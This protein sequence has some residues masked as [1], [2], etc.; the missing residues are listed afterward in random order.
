MLNLTKAIYAKATGTNFKAALTGLYKGRAPENVD[1]PYAVYKVVTD[2]PDKTF[3]EDY[4]DVT[5]QFS[6]FSSSNGTTE[7]ENIYTQLKAVYDECELSI[8][9]ATLVWMKRN[10]AAFQA[11]EHTTQSGMSRIWAYHV[12]YSILESLT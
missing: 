6:L 1:Y 5:L 3:S 2:V 10:Y 4:E 9:G 11:E 12:E 8:T 7:I